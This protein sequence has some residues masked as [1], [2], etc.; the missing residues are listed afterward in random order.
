MTLKAVMTERGYTFEQLQAQ[1]WREA[2]LA[3]AG[4]LA[5]AI[6]LSQV[7]EMGLA[8]AIDHGSAH[9]LILFAG[10]DAPQ[11]AFAGS[12]NGSG[13]GLSVTLAR[14]PSTQNGPVVP[15]T[16]FTLDVPEGTDEDGVRQALSAVGE[17]AVEPRLA[18]DPLTQLP[19]EDAGRLVRTVAETMWATG[20]GVDMLLVTATLLAVW[21]KM[22]Q[23][24]T[25]TLSLTLTGLSQ[26]NE[27]V[28]PGE[29]FT[30]LAR[31]SDGG[32]EPAAPAAEGER[33]EARVRWRPH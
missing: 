15:E 13:A 9:L 28:G 10:L 23:T 7:A 11:L 19:A 31:R 22:E 20:D 25:G 30:L 21:R 6:G 16:E 14:A 1:D 3:D 5:Q 33:M 18:L 27:P 12:W 8:A 26:R 29:Q 24:N 32:F 4:A 2:P 17:E